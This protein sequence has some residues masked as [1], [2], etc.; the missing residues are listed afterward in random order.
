MSALARLRV[1]RCEPAGAMLVCAMKPASSSAPSQQRG[2]SRLWL[3][4]YAEHCGLGARSRTAHR[5]AYDLAFPYYTGPYHTTVRLLCG[6]GYGTRSL[7]SRNVSARP[8]RPRGQV[9]RPHA[10]PEPRDD[11]AVVRV[12]GE[13][14]PVSTNAGRSADAAM[15]CTPWALRE[16]CGALHEYSLV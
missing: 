14:A 8:G 15:P 13:R 5:I 16:Y 2:N 6:L 10:P 1:D 9:R 12:H 4:E 3:A 11:L 7:R